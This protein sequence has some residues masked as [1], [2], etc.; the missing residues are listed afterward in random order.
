LFDNPNKSNDS[1]SRK[2]ALH[3]KRKCAFYQVQ[4]QYALISL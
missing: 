2:T 1:L 4:P 3:C